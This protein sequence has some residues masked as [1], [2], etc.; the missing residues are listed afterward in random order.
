MSVQHKSGQSGDTI[1]EV[2]IAIAVA[3]AVLGA[4]FSTMNRNLLVT[5]ASQERSEA[6]KFAQGQLES[7]KAYT[8]SK[9]PVPAGNFCLNGVTTFP[10]AGGSPTAVAAAD[11]LSNYPAQCKLN[12]YN[13]GIVNDSPRNY[14]IYVRWDRIG[15]GRD[16]IIMVY[17]TAN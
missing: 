5:R 10:V 16:E 3:S 9:L 8:D 12:F 17:R 2:L 14:H 13:A 7:L 15:G 1:V 4:A 6:A 11:N